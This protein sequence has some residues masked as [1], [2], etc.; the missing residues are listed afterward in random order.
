MR[1]LIKSKVN[2]RRRF[3]YRTVL[4]KSRY[5]ADVKWNDLSI[6]T[7]GRPII[8]MDPSLRIEF[9]EADAA[10]WGCC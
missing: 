5:I 9:V 4:R 8:V 7:Y 6:S 2:L 3:N 10:A 1:I